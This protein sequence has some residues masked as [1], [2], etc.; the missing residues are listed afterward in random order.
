M[1]SPF[2]YLIQVTSGSSGLCVLWWAIDIIISAIMAEKK[3]PSQIGLTIPNIDHKEYRGILDNIL[4]E[5]DHVA[6]RAYGCSLN[7]FHGG[8]VHLLLLMIVI[9]NSKIYYLMLQVLVAD[10][11][12][13]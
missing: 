6:Q 13:Q 2:I 5:I 12:S 3:Q 8:G 4:D 9:L 11:W 1:D 7:E 10:T